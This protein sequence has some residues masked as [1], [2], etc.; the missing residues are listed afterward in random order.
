MQIVTLSQ[1][2]IRLSITL[3]LYYPLRSTTTRHQMQQKHITID[4]HSHKRLPSLVIYSRR[5]SAVKP[6]TKVTSQS[7][8]EQVTCRRMNRVR[9]HA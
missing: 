4:D 1:S 5:T 9:D 8:S 2:V 6:C 7:P 3:H